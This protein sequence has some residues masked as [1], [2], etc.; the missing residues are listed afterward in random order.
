MIRQQ[1]AV[2]GFDWTYWRSDEQDVRELGSVRAA[3]I[4]F[5]MYLINKFEHEILLLKEQGCVWGPVHSSVGQE[6]VAAA[7]VAALSRRD[8]ITGSHRAHHQFLSKALNYVVPEDWN[9]LEMDLPEQ[10]EEVLRRTMA[11]I[12]G[13]APGYCGGRGGSMH[14]R[15]A[16]AGILGTNAIVGGGVPLSTGAAFAEQYRKGDG[17]MVC[18]FGDGAANQ[19][20]FH[21]AL[22]LAGLWRLPIVYVIENNRYAVGTAHEQACAVADLSLRA[23]SYNLR[24]Y[25]V[26]GTDVAAVYGAAS[27]CVQKTRTGSGPALIEVRCYRHYH[28]AGDRPGSVYGY[29]DRR[30]EEEQFRRDPLRTFPEALQSTGVVT[31]GGLARLE[32]MA[33][34]AVLQA[35]QFCTSGGKPRTVRSELWPDPETAAV[36]VRSSGEELQTL[37]YKERE[38]FREFEELKFS[39]A[40]AGVAGRWMER[41]P[42]VVELGEEVANFNGGAYGATKGLPA[43]FPGQVVNTPISEAGFVGLALGAAMSG[44]RPIVEIMFPDFALVAADQLFNQI[45]KA[46]HMYGGA[47]D[48]PLVARTRI[49]SGCG[50]GGQHSMDPVGLF[51]LFSGWRIAA[52]SDAFDYI[53]MFNTAMYC[54][55][56]VLFLE[57]HSLY[58]RTCTVPLGD[59]DYCIPFG[60]A[61]VVF[62]GGDCT[63]LCYSSLTQRL[64]ALRDDLAS[65]GVS[66]ELIDLRTVDLP[67]M[68]FDT[69][70]ASVKKTGAVA[71]LEEAASGQGIGGRLAAEI[72]SRFFDELDAP[73]LCVASLDVPN[74]VSRVLESA[75][76]LSDRTI[77]TALTDLARRR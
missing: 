70:G 22:N 62:S 37:K 39:D 10:G 3:C 54:R 35:V 49:A 38:D 14:L 36:G 30:E 24:A 51:A 5:Q 50:Y 8:R 56:P 74:S 55:D 63:V 17:V 43:R 47:T 40:I 33:G 64:I 7:A 21:E 2:E 18:F 69:I 1:L 23:C 77:L 9:P 75:A 34:A 4:Y 67:A 12:M 65:R 72:T 6:A 11:E 52:P 26:E 29:R 45:A 60:K 61:R 48:L 68:D 44:L 19:G 58:S 76:L 66:V 57:H 16:E 42:G 25:L 53:G 32:K 73:P 46:R 71:V 41:D 59:L 20:V 31:A 27:D 15:W 13:L 28:H